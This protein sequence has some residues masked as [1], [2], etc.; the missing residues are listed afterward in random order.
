MSGIVPII[1]AA[2]LIPILVRLGF[3]IVRQE[4]SHIHLQNQF[5]KTY[6]VT[7]PAHNRDLP[8]KTLLSILKQAKIPLKEFLKILGR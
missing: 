2:R 5:D 3:R 4:G 8:K 7:I 6:K 1:R